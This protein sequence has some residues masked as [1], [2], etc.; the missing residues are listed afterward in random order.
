[1]RLLRDLAPVR[2]DA[3]GDAQ[4][5]RQ[6]PGSAVRVRLDDHVRL[7]RRGAD[8]PPRPRARRDVNMLL[9]RWREVLVGIALGALGY[10]T[11]LLLPVSWRVVFEGALVAWIGS[12]YIGFGLVSGTRSAIIEGAGGVLMLLLAVF[13]TSWSA[14][15]LTAALIFHAGWD[16]AHH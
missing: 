11:A 15:L 10:G 16:L 7:S 4:G 1:A 2:V 3:G 6:L 14:W 5:D 8:L 12:V 13:G 9:S